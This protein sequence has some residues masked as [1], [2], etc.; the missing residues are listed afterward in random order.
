MRECNCQACHQ[1]GE[2]GGTI[3]AVVEDQLESS[4]GDTLQA[5]ALSPPILYNEKSKIG[6]G[7]RVHTDWL[8]GFLTSPRTSPALAELRMPTFQFTRRS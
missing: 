2:K 6:E 8:H 3:R 5:Q 7:A 1:I 4:G